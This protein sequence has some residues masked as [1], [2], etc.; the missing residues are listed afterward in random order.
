M[1]VDYQCTFAVSVVAGFGG[2]IL[3]V[4]ITQVVLTP[5]YLGVA[6][7]PTIMLYSS[8][9][10][11][12]IFN[13]EAQAISSVDFEIAYYNVT[14]LVTP[15]V[16]TRVEDYPATTSIN[17]GTCTTYEIYA[18]LLGTQPYSYSST[19]YI[20]RFFKFLA[21]TPQGLT[22]LI[23]ENGRAQV[24]Y[25]IN[26][27]AN[28]TKYIEYKSPDVTLEYQAVTVPISYG[29][30]SHNIQ[31]YEYLGY[32]WYKDGVYQGFI[33]NLY[34]PNTLPDSNKECQYSIL[35]TGISDNYGD[36]ASCR[37][38]DEEQ[39][40]TLQSD[41]RN[42]EGNFVPSTNYISTLT[43]MDNI[44]YIT[45]SSNDPTT[46]ITLAIFNYDFEPVYQYHPEQVQNAANYPYAI[47]DG[48]LVKFEDIE[49]NTSGEIAGIP[50]Y[51]NYG[52]AIQ[53][54][55]SQEYLVNPGNLGQV[56]GYS[57]QVNS[58]ITLNRLR[59]PEYTSSPFLLE[60]DKTYFTKDLSSIFEEPPGRI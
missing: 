57:Q 39:S 51:K 37:I 11:S 26:N 12:F 48:N 54:L 15:P 41:S 21:G 17:S 8:T 2:F 19:I 49:N 46:G 22:S 28:H 45:R 5:G 53:N 10:R 1:T 43:D 29:P 42:L 7:P 9:V 58:A 18:T 32:D 38:F 56:L 36:T 23:G 24:G 3:G 55:V 40:V 44:T 50:L 33:T 4:N 52:L 14:S 31:N 34:F 25:Y 59:Q 6:S 13:E 60:Y 35:T 47:I 27:A 16:V 30:Y 20:S